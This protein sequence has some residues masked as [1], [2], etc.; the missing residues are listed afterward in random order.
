MRSAMTVPEMLHSVALAI[1]NAA[2]VA[3]M[4][5]SVPD[6]CNIWSTH[7]LENDLALDSI[8]RVL[9]AVDLEERHRIAFPHGQEN[10]WQTVMDVVAS[11]HAALGRP[12]AA[13]PHAAGTPAP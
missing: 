13:R 9:L 12:A 3:G 1:V 7:H 8:D 5:G 2:T 4:P 11:L 10:R 6:A